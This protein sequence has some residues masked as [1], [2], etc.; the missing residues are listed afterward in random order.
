MFI[1]S[2]IKNWLKYK[3][4]RKKNCSI[5]SIHCWRWR[6]HI[7]KTIISFGETD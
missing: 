6:K 5:K 4:Y 2:S 7:N 3:Y 1:K